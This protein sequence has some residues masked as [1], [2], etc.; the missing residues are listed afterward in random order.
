MARRAES[1]GAAGTG[2]AI[3]SGRAAAAGATAAG[4]EA[5]AD[6]GAT[7]RSESAGSAAAAPDSIV[8]SSAMAAA[9]RR[10]LI[11]LTRERNA[12]PLQQKRGR[13]AAPARVCL[14]GP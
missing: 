12:S 8:P 13:C 1:G 3:E 7:A 6:A 5:A 11:D 9:I 2:A 10:R 4:A 14:G